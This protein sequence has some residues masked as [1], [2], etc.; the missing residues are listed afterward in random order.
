MTFSLYPPYPPFRSTSDA[1]VH[2]WT[3][4]GVAWAPFWTKGTPGPKQKGSKV[5]MTW[6]DPE[7]LEDLDA[8]NIAST[9][10]PSPEKVWS[11]EGKDSGESTG[12]RRGNDAPPLQPPPTSPAAAVVGDEK[13]NPRLRTLVDDLAVT[14]GQAISHG[15][16]SRGGK[17][18]PH[19]WDIVEFICGSAVGPGG[20][21]GTGDNDATGGDAGAADGVDGAEG[22]GAV[23][24]EGAPATARIIDPEVADAIGAAVD[25]ARLLAAGINTVEG[26]NAKMQAL[27]RLGLNKGRCNRCDDPA[28][29]TRSRRE[30]S[31]AGRSPSLEGGGAP[32]RWS[33]C[34]LSVSPWQP[35]RTRMYVFVCMLT[36]A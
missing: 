26:V 5:V 30:R 27:V 32:R 22:H 14:L 13:R 3:G 21:A 24:P 16:V 17:L 31:L 11:P 15:G 20:A 8:P 23:P 7:D 12:G 34:R 10:T 2:A 19:A 6:E 9:P 4:C 18:P 1:D 29:R 35:V 25:T 33:C 28:F 36:E